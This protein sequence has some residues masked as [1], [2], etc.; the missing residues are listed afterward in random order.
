MIGEHLDSFTYERILGNALSRVPNTVDKR[1]GSIIF[2]AIAPVCAELAQM[3]IALKGIHVQTYA[4]TATGENLDLR[5]AEEGLTR[6]PA[7]YAI[8]RGIFVGR[9]GNPKEVPIGNRFST[10][11][12][13][14]N[15]NYIVVDTY[16]D[17]KGDTVPGAYMLQSE[18]AGSVGNGYIGDM[19]PITPINDLQEAHMND[20]LIPARD[21]ETDEELRV[22]YQ[23]R[24]EVKS[25][26]GNIA[27]YDEKIR[28]LDGV[29]DVQ[30]YPVWQGGGTVK[31]SIIGVDFSPASQ[32]LIDK[33]Q[34]VIDPSDMNVKGKGIGLAPIDHKVTIVTAI[35]APMN[36]AADIS[37]ASGYNAGQVIN[38]VKESIAAY[39]LSIRKQWGT[40]DDY[41]NYWQDIFIS[42]I[43]FAILSVKGVAN[44]TGTTLNGGTVDI[45][46]QQTA[47]V[48]ELPMLGEVAINAS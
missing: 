13:G 37:L 39:L 4:L 33:V 47:M 18:V 43:N 46:L 35:S 45:S 27:E 15:I 20:L 32:M 5:V 41:N 12:L 29:G 36:I 17:K 22:R 14:T 10:V 1:E 34:E 30:I 44:V 16:K 21:E 8:K 2:D 28:N 38:Q 11:N 9:G 31:C 19:M 3:Y 48:Q 40:P 23:E 24:V 25:F 26:G 7:T 42:Q 6:F